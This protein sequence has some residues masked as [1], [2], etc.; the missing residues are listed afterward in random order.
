LTSKNQWYIVNYII[1]HK[2]ST[3]A[4]SRW[5]GNSLGEFLPDGALPEPWDALLEDSFTPYETREAF[6]LADLLYCE[7]QMPQKQIDRLLHIWAR[8]LIDV[9]RNPPFSRARDL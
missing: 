7:N 6:E 2:K 4:F 9:G 3:I 5:P 8:T 1:T